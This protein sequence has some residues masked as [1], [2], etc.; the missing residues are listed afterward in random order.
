MLKFNGKTMKKAVVAEEFAVEDEN[1][2]ISR[3]GGYDSVMAKPGME[4][5][6]INKAECENYGSTEMSLCWIPKF[7][8]ATTLASKFVDHI[9]TESPEEREALDMIDTTS[10]Q[11]ESLAKGNVVEWDGEDELPPIGCKVMTSFTESDC[12]NWCDFHG[13]SEIIAYHNDYVWVAHHGKFNRIHALSNIEFEKPESPEQKAERERLEAAY[14]LY[15]KVQERDEGPG[16]AASFKQFQDGMM[17]TCRKD[18]LSIVDITGYRK[19]S[20]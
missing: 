18:Y 19:D 9:P 2:C 16:F 4:L 10:K 1:F 17:S 11:V 5:W 8:F 7:G 3:T 20:K 15:L 14:D 6:V 12:D 13:P